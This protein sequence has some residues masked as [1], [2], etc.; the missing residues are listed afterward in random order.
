MRCYTGGTEARDFL[1]FVLIIQLLIN[2]F[3][4]GCELAGMSDFEHCAYR[5]PEISL[6]R[7][8]HVTFCYQVVQQ[9]TYLK[10]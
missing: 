9:C 10:F 8:S 3:K 2:L 4:V 7:L 6:K 5:T 1:S